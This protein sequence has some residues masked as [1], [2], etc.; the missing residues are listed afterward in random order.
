MIQVT[1][2]ASLTQL[3]SHSPTSAL[4]IFDKLNVQQMTLKENDTEF[5][6]TDEWHCV[7][8]NNIIMMYP[9][10]LQ[11]GQ[12]HQPSYIA[13]ELNQLEHTWWL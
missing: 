1:S 13:G 11:S 2:L 4:Q 6:Q 5:K 8:G 12:K 9:G 3:A 10:Q 7:H